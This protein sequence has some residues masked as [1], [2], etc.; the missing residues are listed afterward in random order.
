M[1]NDRSA[2]CVTR[3]TVTN[4]GRCIIALCSTIGLRRVYREL[5]L[6]T[7]GVVPSRCVEDRCTSCVSRVTVTNVGRCTIALCSRIGLRRVSR[8]LPLLTLGVV[9]SRRVYRELPLLTL[10]VVPSR[11]GRG[12]V[13][14]VHLLHFAVYE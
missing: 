10:D 2:S 4:V 6:L 9:P 14:V 7:L 1:F 3:V 8:E 5:P 11:C 13:C 12:S